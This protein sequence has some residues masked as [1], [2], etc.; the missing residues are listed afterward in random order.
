MRVLRNYR[1]PYYNT[2]CWFLFAASGLGPLL[3]RKRRSKA[4]KAPAP[5]TRTPLSP[6]QTRLLDEPEAIEQTPS[7]SD[8]GNI[9]LSIFF[10]HLSHLL[11]R[12]HENHFRLSHF[13]LFY[14]IYSASY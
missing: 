12:F 5:P 3:L 14:I 11:W 13:N 7:T 1:M 8:T 9:L 10:I 4:R 6:E 2:I